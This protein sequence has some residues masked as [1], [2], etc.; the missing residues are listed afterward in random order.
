MADRR[1]IGRLLAATLLLGVLTSCS[2]DDSPSA[3][4]EQNTETTGKP[5][6]AKAA[7]PPD[8]GSCYRIS[9]DDALAPTSTH[10][11]VDCNGPHSSQTY[12]VGQLDLVVDGHL[13]A[14]DSD[15]A[16]N[17]LT[18]ACQRRFA[19]YVGGSVE[20]RRLSMLVGFGFSPTLEQS[21]RGH[22]WF[23]CDVVA[24]ATPGRLARL[25]GQLD[26]VLDS[27]AG[28]SRWGRCATAEPGTDD[29]EHIVCSRN[30]SWR[31]V[32]TAEVAA[33][34][35]DGWPGLKAAKR[36]G[37]AC[38]DKVR[39]VADS[40]FNFEWGYEWPTQEQWEAGQHYG[41]CWTPN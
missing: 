18:A 1:V 27:A 14:V 40:P 15:R 20:A 36:A 13:L 11:A 9:Y 37:R 8:V 41:F 24:Q 12:Y 29:S 17:Q 25:K 30:N 3:D 16:Y 4:P 5:R 34:D 38:E 35:D 7:E 32:A 26:G 28:R 31:A 10:K 22:S 19:A 33:G 2:D 23:R 39:V 6:P 21:E